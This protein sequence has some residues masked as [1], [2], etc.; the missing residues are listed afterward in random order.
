MSRPNRESVDARY[1]PPEEWDQRYQDNRPGD[2]TFDEED[3]ER[4][5]VIVCLPGGHYGTCPIRT[6]DSRSP[7]WAFNGSTEKPTLSPSILVKGGKDGGELWHGWLRDGRF[8]S[9]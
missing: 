3:G 1:V 8:V 9:C 5:A 2:W 4:V 6:K 7:H